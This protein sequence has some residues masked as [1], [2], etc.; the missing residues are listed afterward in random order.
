VELRY[1]RTPDGSAATDEH[2][3]N[4]AHW[5]VCLTEVEGYVDT[6]TRTPDIAQEWVC[7]RRC[8]LML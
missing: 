4:P 3:T 8:D 6:K 5:A 2:V 7:G 1:L